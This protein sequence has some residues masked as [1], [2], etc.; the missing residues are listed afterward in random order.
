MKKN[1]TYILLTLILLVNS[2]S[3][4]TQTNKIENITISPPVDIPIY[5]SGTFGELRQNHFHS[6]ID[7]KTQGIEGKNIIAIADGWIS[8]IKI[9]EGGYGKAIYITHSNGY[10]SVYGHLQKFSTTI[11][12]LVIAKQYE[13]ESFTIQIF[14]DKDEIK[15]KKGEVI[16][17]SGNTG[18]SQ[19][20]HLHFEIREER[21]QHPVNPLLN[22]NIKI[23]DFYRPSI[24]KLAIYPVDVNSTINGKHDT[25]VLDIAGWGAEHRIKDNVGITV[26]GKI[27]FGI[28]TIDKMND[29]SNKNGVYSI[30]LLNDTSLIFHLNMSELSFNTTRYINSVIDYS[31]YKKTKTRIVR[32]QIDTNNIFDNYLIV[33]NNG[34]INFNDTLTHNFSFEVKDAYDNVANLSFKIKSE[35][36]K[37][38]QYENKDTN[39]H[40]YFDKSNSLVKD[41]IQVSFPSNSFYQ[42]FNFDYEKYEKDSISLSAIYKLHN[43]LTPVHKYFSI[44]IIPNRIILEKENKAY[45]SY[46]PDNS[47]YSFVESKKEGNYITCRSRQLGYYKI[48]IDTIPPDIK[49][50]NFYNK[51]ALTKQNTLKLK[52]K[53][54]ETGIKTYRATLN[55]KWI[56]M[57]FDSKKNLLVYTFDDRITKGKNEF[58]LEVSDLLGNTNV[59]NCVVTY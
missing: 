56:L 4:F 54:N 17:Y 27:S 18:G 46:S 11:Q 31:Y 34:I 38:N 3:C 32:T 48:M 12:N 10:I 19:G 49:E 14:P 47:D 9:S 36:E 2:I 41:S 20:P 50:V 52:I 26:S 45:I 59:Y 37:N 1:I 21:S 35:D 58:K 55:N 44:K 30:K 5:L 33:K 43:R 15:V 53:D 22:K 28:S 8:R 40:F 16:A 23:K 39:T 57:E 6:G 29:I 51:K 42:S 7:I 13:K 25:L 24:S